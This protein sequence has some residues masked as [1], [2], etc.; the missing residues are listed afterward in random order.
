M[1]QKVTGLTY[2]EAGVDIDAGNRLV[3]M[4]RS[5]VRS[6]RRAGA[7]GEIGGFGGVFDLEYES[8][9]CI[10]PRWRHRYPP[11][12]THNRERCFA[13]RLPSTLAPTLAPR[14]HVAWRWLPVAEAAQ[15]V[16]SWSNAAVFAALSVKIAG[17]RSG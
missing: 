6:T 11:G 10:Y 3:D 5:A 1:Q 14:E 8:V 16:T 2:A 15:V 9:Y 12:T 17:H 4:I 13:L 7:D